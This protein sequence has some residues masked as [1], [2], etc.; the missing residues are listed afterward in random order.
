M[1]T[2]T[3]NLMGSIRSEWISGELKRPPKK[4]APFITIARQPGAGGRTMARV[5]AERLNEEARQNEQW[6]MY[7]RELVEK[8]AEDHE[9]STR[10]VESLEDSSH[11]WLRGVLHAW[12]NPREPSELAVFHRVAATVRALAEGGRAI[13]VGRGSVFLTRDLP[14]G[15]HVYLVPPFDDRVERM[16]QKWNLST[17]ATATKLRELEQYRNEYYERHFST[18]PFVPETFTITINTADISPE[19]AADIVVPAVAALKS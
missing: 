16:A 14:A 19:Q 12:L 6:R 3:I 11:N 2:E 9:L 17:D 1:A 8:V 5:L 18:K 7:D 13:I 15:L 10:M 4:T